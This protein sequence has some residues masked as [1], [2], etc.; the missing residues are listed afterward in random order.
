[1]SADVAD[2]VVHK[3]VQSKQFALPLNEN[4]DTSNEAKLVAFVPS[5]RNCGEHILFYRFFKG[6]STGRTIF[7]FF[8]NDH[9]NKWQWFEATCTGDAEAMTGR[10]SSLVSRG[11]KTTAQLLLMTVIICRQALVSNKL[12]QTFTYNRRRNK[13]MFYDNSTI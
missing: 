6:N 4:T 13:V 8:F 5:S 1:M 3:T 7:K 11:K 12:N 2:Q 10:L 9:T